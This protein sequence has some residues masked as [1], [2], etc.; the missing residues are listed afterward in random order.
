ME[1]IDNEQI[2]KLLEDIASIKEVINRNRPVIQQVVN[3]AHFRLLML[4][5]GASVIFFSLFYHFLDQYYGDY[6]TVPLKL[7]WG[8][9]TGIAV[10]AVVLSIM[11]QRLYLSSI[12]KIDPSLTL[13]WWFKEIF[14]T[15]FA[16]IYF[17]SIL[18]NIF[19]IIIFIVKDIPFYIVPLLSIWIGLLGISGAMLRIRYT[20]VMGYWFLITGLLLL[21]FNT[22]PLF[23]ALIITFGTGFLIMAVLGYREHR[24]KKAE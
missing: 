13:S 12:K 15:G 10:V 8:F 19:L 22:V 5:S 23:I 9:Y 4:L 20:L 2:D 24:S 3:L 6:S 21:I 1:A 7:K 16:H 17:S 11:K 18:T 14:S